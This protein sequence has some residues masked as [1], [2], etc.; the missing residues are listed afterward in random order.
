MREVR[1]DGH[2]AALLTAGLDPV[3]SLVS[4]AGVGAAPKE[5]FASRGWSDD[6]WDAATQRLVERGWLNADG[7]ATATGHEGRA[8]IERMTDELAAP[9]YRALGAERVGRFA[10]LVL[11]VT[12]TVVQTGLLPQQS[13]LGLG[14]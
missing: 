6:E 13:T 2:V 9:A 7:T 3:E 12:M 10:E 11:P 14:R 8:E 5:V 1:G 4:F